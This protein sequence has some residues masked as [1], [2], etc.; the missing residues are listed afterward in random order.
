M[1]SY[2]TKVH[3]CLPRNPADLTSYTKNGDTNSEINSIAEHAGCWN[4]LKIYWFSHM[5][6]SG[7]ITRYLFHHNSHRST[8]KLNRIKLIILNW[9]YILLT[10]TYYSKIG[11][12]RIP[13]GENILSPIEKNKCSQSTSLFRPFAWKNMIHQDHRHF[14]L[15]WRGLQTCLTDSFWPILSKILHGHCLFGFLYDQ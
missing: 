6:C 4:V 11:L 5:C 8:L 7:Q 13:L 1:S 9:M 14:L 15:H 12:G 2:A 10:C 3:Q